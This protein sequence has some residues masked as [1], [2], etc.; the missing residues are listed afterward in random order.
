M[1]ENTRFG[2]PG[3][4]N[5]IDARTRYFDAAVNDAVARGTCQVRAFLTFSLMSCK[6][7]KDPFQVISSDLFHS[8]TGTSW[9]LSYG[10]VM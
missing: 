8:Q 3:C 10:H 5:F 2:V 1:L 6:Q 4:I 7:I 9:M